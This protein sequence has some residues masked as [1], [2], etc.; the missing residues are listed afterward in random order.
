MIGIAKNYSG[1]SPISLCYFK[2]VIDIEKS[3][4]IKKAQVN[5]MKKNNMV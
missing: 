2:N 1:F 4:I 5:E 3:E